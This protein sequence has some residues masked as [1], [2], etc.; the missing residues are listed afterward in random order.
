MPGSAVLADALMLQ[1]L[2]VQLAV[3]AEDHALAAEWIEANRR[4][5]QWSGAIAGQ[6]EHHVAAAC[7]ELAREDTDAAMCHA[8]QAV[9]LSASP[10]QPLARIDALRVRGTV[11]GMLGDRERACAD[12]QDALALADQCSAPFERARVLV[13]MAQVTGDLSG[14]TEAVRVASRLHAAPLHQRIDL[15]LSREQST[16]GSASRRASWRCSGMPHRG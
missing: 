14:I 11:A 13:E 5:L 4:W 9:D 8:A 6:V 15:L 3:S 12:F 16:T 1:P 2:A 7:L 10:L